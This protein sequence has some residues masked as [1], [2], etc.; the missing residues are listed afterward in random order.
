MYE[1]FQNKVHLSYGVYT[2][3]AIRM[4]LHVPGTN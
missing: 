1:L 2:S 4:M 3:V